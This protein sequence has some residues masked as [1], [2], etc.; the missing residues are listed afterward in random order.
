MQQS[1]GQVEAQQSYFALDPIVRFR[2]SEPEEQNTDGKNSHPWKRRRKQLTT[3]EDETG[4]SRSN[5]YRL[6]RLG[7]FPKPIRLGGNAIG[8]RLSSI[9][10]WVAERE[11]AA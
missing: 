11:G 2:F 9:R 5:I 3:V 8:W 10:Q 6:I 7:Q 4:Q 1:T